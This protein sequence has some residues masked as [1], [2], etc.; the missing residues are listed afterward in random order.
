[1]V[2]TSNHHSSARPLYMCA[3]E[4]N[5]TAYVLQCCFIIIQCS[6]R[7]NQNLWEA[8]LL[9][10]L[11]SCYVPLRLP[12]PP[13]VSVNPTSMMQRSCLLESN[14]HL[15][16]REDD[17]SST[18]SYL[19]STTPLFAPFSHVFGN[20]ATLGMKSKSCPPPPVKQ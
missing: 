20:H 10:C 16:N 12:P 2:N 19:F 6:A 18:R 5:G 8:K 9:V 1:M 13:K 11:L 4:V 3:L 7:I 17:P 15:S 14:L